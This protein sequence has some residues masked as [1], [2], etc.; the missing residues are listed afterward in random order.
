MPL[1][2]AAGMDEESARAAALRLLGDQL[3]V[4]SRQLPLWHRLSLLTRAPQMNYN[5]FA[6]AMVEEQITGESFPLVLLQMA[7]AFSNIDVDDK[8]CVMSHR[9]CETPWHG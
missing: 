6:A 2:K 1:L 8:L 4:R 7:K 9:R 5:Q 3:T